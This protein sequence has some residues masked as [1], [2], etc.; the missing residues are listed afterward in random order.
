MSSGTYFVSAW[1]SD[2]LT[3]YGVAS[4]SVKKSGTAVVAAPAGQ[5]EADD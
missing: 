5:G 4:T 3:Y 2:P 1:G